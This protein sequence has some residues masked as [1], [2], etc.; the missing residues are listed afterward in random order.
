MS[1][2]AITQVPA[3]AAASVETKFRR[4]LLVASL[5]SALALLSY[6]GTMLWAQNSL[7]GPES[8]VAAQATMLAHDGTLYYDLNQYP[9]TVSAYMPIFYFLD[10][11]LIK[12][13]IPAFVAGRLISFAALLGLIAMCRLIAL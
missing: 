10:A 7:S 4:G 5:L 3:I 1:V 8:V 2:G 9:Y 13:G 12:L 11:G 6:C